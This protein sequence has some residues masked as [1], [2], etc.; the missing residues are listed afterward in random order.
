MKKELIFNTDL[1]FEH[2]NWS[3]E[4][5]FWIDE[6]S[7][8]QNRL[9]E[10]VTRWT[11]K[12]VL[13]QVDKFQNKFTIQRDSFNEIE[14]QIEMHESNVA[15][16]YMKN[17]DAMNKDLVKKHLAMRDRMEEQRNLFHGIKKDFFKFLTQYM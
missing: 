16:H 13:A 2:E 6:L 12:D 8:F 7:S 15:D 4:L 11:D 5:K 9:D 14:N 1:H 10:L 3:R 17:E